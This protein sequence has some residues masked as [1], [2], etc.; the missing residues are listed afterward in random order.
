MADCAPMGR[1]YDAA[2]WT[3]AAVVGISFG[4]MVALEL[5]VSHPERVERLA[6]LCTSAGGG[7]VL[8]P[9]HQLEGPTPERAAVRRTL[10]DSAV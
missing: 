6:L 7:E 5:A 10:I 9:F 4:G 8:Y 3:S 1:G 2:G